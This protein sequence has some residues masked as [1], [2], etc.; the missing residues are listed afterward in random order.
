MFQ[1]AN[2]AKLV[3]AFT[4]IIL[5]GFVIAHLAGNLQV[6]AGPDQLNGYAMHL[7]DLGPLLWGLRIV[8]LIALFVHI[9]AA[10]SLTKQN[11]DARP[12]PYAKPLNFPASSPLSR[13][14]LLT[15]WTIAAFVVYHLGHFTFLVTNPSYKELHWKFHDG[16]EWHDVYGMVVVAFSNPWIVVLYLIAQ[17]FLW[18]HLSHALSSVFQTLGLKNARNESF[19]N[20][21][22]PVVATAIFI[23]YASI[24]LGVLTGVIRAVTQQH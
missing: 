7:R 5:F 21:I 22:G 8:L 19:I 1:T 14:M 16:T 6:F 23:G 10:I 17:V 2:S 15:G 20:A 11:N 3:M 12:T 4:G 13:H 9:A 24:P 18:M